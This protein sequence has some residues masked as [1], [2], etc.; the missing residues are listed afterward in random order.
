[1][2]PHK[3]VAEVSKTGNLWERWVV[4]MHGWQGELMDGK[5]V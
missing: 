3:G 1:M 4:A 2:V 5:V